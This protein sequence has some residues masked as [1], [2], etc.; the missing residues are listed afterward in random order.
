LPIVTTTYNTATLDL[1]TELFIGATVSPD[2]KYVTLTVEPIVSQLLG[3][4][5]FPFTPT[6]PVL[7]GQS[8]VQ[9]PDL[10][11]QTLRTTVSVPDGGTLLLGGLKSSGEVEREEG[12]PLLSK[13]PI[14]NR[15]FTN[16]GKVIDESTLL[17][18]IK[19]TVI[20]PRD[21]E[22]KLFP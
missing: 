21:E 19:P 1:G 4:N 17:I 22:K 20:V 5:F 18:L 16:R 2:L 8:F 7:P 14:I 15:A 11:I 12:V 9:L 6:G 13:I 3:L 10:S